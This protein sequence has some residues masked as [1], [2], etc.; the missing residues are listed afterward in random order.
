VDD[1]ERGQELDQANC[2]AALRAQLAR[3]AAEAAEERRGT[4]GLCVVCDEPIPTARLQAQPNAVRCIEC[5]ERK[6]K[7]GD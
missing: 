3:V 5:Q 2:A 4:P 7:Y 1:V 6:E